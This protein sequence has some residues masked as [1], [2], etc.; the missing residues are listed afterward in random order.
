MDGDC[1]CVR[2]AKVPFARVHELFDDVC[3]RCRS[4]YEDH[5][6]VS[7]ALLFE[8]LLVVLRLVEADDPRHIEVSENLCV[9]RG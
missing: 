8:R 1:T 9:A 2:L 3:G 5:V 4:I 7:D 6:V